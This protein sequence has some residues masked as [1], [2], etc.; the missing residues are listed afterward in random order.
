MYAWHAFRKFVMRLQHAILWGISVAG[1]NKGL[2]IHLCITQSAAARLL[3]RVQE[4]LRFKR[5]SSTER[6][7]KLDWSENYSYPNS[8]FIGVDPHSGS[9][10]IDHRTSEISLKELIVRRGQPFK[11]TLKLAKPFNPAFDELIMTVKTGDHPSEDLGTMS[12]FGVPD[13]VQ[14]L[15]SAKAVWKAELQRSTAPA[16]G[17][18][19]LS[20]TP[21]V[22]SP[23]GE[24]TMSARL[25]E[26]ERALA[27]LS[28]LFNPWCPGDMVFMP[29]EVERKEYVMNE[30]G[31]I[32]KGVDNYISPI[33]WDYGQF[34]EDMVSICVKILD[35]SIKHKQDPAKD[36]SARCN[37]IYVSRVITSMINSENEGGILK[38]NWG[39]DFRGGV[40]PT[41]W[42]SS[43]PI[44]KQ[45]FNACFCSVKYG[46]CWVFSG[47]MCSV[48]RL[49]GIPCRVVTN[50]QSAHD[51]NKNLTVDTYFADYG[52]REKESKD[53]VWNYHVW[54]EGWM[55]RP[56]LAKDG[57]Y[58]GWQVLDPTP[59]EKSDGMFC[60][61]PAPVSAVRNGDT[62]LKYD[63]PFVFAEVNADCITW[64]VKRDRSK[65]KI[66]S[67]DHRI[68]QSIS[69]K[70][71]GT[72]KRMD[73]TDSYKQKEG[74]KQERTVFQYAL[75]RVEE[76]GEGETCIIG[77]KVENGTT[78]TNNGSIEATTQ[79]EEQICSPTPPPQLFIRFEE[80]SRPVNGEDV[81]V[82]LVLNSDSKVVRLLSINISVQAMRY[83]G[84]PAG[85]ILANSTEQQLMPG[86]DL[87]IP[88][89]VPYSRYQKLM[90]D[91]ESMNIAAMVTD[92]RKKNHVFLAENRIVLMNPPIVIT[93]QGEGRVNKEITVEVLFMN[94]LNEILRNCSLTLS[95]SG[96][97]REELI[98]KVPDLPPKNRVRVMF[99]VIPYRSG[100]RTLLVDF[101]CASFRDIKKSSTV[102]IRP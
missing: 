89:L 78:D 29:D 82:R 85:N 4:F 10:N 75:S 50:Y 90:I 66:H 34:E 83:T 37:A 15:P 5:E 93:V 72:S 65:V 33:H 91:C 52:V 42:S 84:R 101:D 49:L 38:G 102:I 7:M 40:P 28:V 16:T 46:Q 13:K 80:V 48:M 98:T 55:R 32:Y 96:L 58:D 56:D 61:G 51:T 64:L 81:S 22:D 62:H 94:P 27:N 92:Q 31:I 45:W 25:G 43:Y 3:E 59:Q 8:A 86:R 30:Q 95:G 76:G 68:G 67:E 1:C 44:L 23:V 77:E 88:I 63:V 70:A 74:T 79:P 14:R 2:K 26:E 53:S 6:T 9:N 24:Y 73:I 97:L 18:L 11:F 41:H 19:T 20:I 60:C 36:V 99:A 21:S 47:V 35:C 87:I 71:I 100:E 54:V 57:R 39:N 12:R 17:I 69:T